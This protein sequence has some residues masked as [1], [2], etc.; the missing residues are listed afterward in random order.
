MDIYK[1]EAELT[2]PWTRW[3][4]NT[5]WLRYADYTND[6]ENEPD[7]GATLRTTDPAA[8]LRFKK[9]QTSY[10]TQKNDRNNYGNGKL[11][12]EMPRRDFSRTLVN[13]M[14]SH[15]QATGSSAP[16][17]HTASI[18]TQPA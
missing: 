2:A 6:L 15:K 3:P 5:R 13:P 18:A 8:T 1:A 9:T 4:L 12:H 10:K 14:A 17:S 11:S 16:P 7:T